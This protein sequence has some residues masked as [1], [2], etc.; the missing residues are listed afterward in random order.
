[1]NLLESARFIKELV[2]LIR[3]EEQIEKSES[4]PMEALME[5]DEKEIFDLVKSESSPEESEGKNIFKYKRDFSDEDE[6]DEDVQDKDRGHKRRKSSHQNSMEKESTYNT[7]N[8]NNKVISILQK[9]MK[10]RTSLS[11]ISLRL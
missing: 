9:K 1:M 7:Y 6:S 5:E 10:R 11:L 4:T 8:N 3:N 2:S